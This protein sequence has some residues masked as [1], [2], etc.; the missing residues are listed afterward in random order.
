MQPPVNRPA[1]LDASYPSCVSTPT[2]FD[3]KNSSDQQQLKLLLGA[4]R[5][6][7]FDTITEQLR[8]L[9]EI[10]NPTESL[11][12]AQ[13]LEQATAHAGTI[14]WYYGRWV[15]FPWSNTLV[16]LLDKDEFCEVRSSRNRNKITSKEQRLLRDKTIGIVGLSVGNVIATTLAL[17]GVGGSFHIADPDHVALSNTNRILCGVASVGAQKAHFCAQRMLEIDP[18]LN[19]RVFDDGLTEANRSE[20]FDGLDLLVEE[21]DSLP[22]KIRIREHARDLRLPVIMET[23]DRG[24]LDVER[25]DLEPTRAIFHG[26]LEDTSADDLEALV[27][28]AEKLPFI[29][30]LLGGAERLSPRSA[31]SLFEID[32]SLRSWPQLASDT[33]LGGSVVTS[34]VRR[35]LLDEFRES[36]RYYVDV[37]KLIS[38]GQGVD[39]APLRQAAQVPLAPLETDTRALQK[40]RP[41]SQVAP[42]EAEIREMLRL[43]IMAPSGGNIQPWLFHWTG[44]V[45][46]CRVDISRAGGM[47]DGIAQSA[48][49]LAVGAAVENIVLAAQGLGYE[50]TVLYPESPGASVLACEISFSRAASAIDSPLLACVPMRATNRRREARVELPD[51]CLKRLQTIANDGG[52]Q[53]RILQT[54][55]TLQSAASI[56]A[57]VNRLQMYSKQLHREMMSEI[58][59]TQEEARDSGDGLDVATLEASRADIAGLKLLSSWRVVNMIRRTGTGSA[60]DRLM[61]Q[62]IAGASA[63]CLLTLPRWSARS[64]VEG[65][66]IMQRIWLQATLEELGVQPLSSAP[67]L[68]LALERGGAAGLSK[69][70]VDLLK[71]LRKQ[72]LELFELDGSE[73]EVLLFRVFVGG[74]PT[75][76]A[77][78]R[79]VDDVLSVTP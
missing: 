37:A 68:F 9:I 12:D 19:I 75:A 38:E 73:A 63:L 61:N 23:N 52:A 60:L 21:C 78:R 45:L 6:Q 40:T 27:D 22:T 18:Y 28:P 26:L 76:R 46:E 44:R 36:G 59:W 1:G 20:F 32:H 54:P 34:T 7:V 30:R 49:R 16:H 33:V 51:Q 35:I 13:L 55:E 62:W 8:E 67:Y 79:P 4:S 25:F 69:E 29:L 31:A 39:L 65:G 70:D 42:T 74:P 5:P 77:L 47:L 43:G 72:Y 41:G 14:D 10:R 66:Q 57:G 53:L 58:R 2:F 11:T 24:V 15:L 48:S 56:L 64:F 71:P 50:A 17:E 3:P